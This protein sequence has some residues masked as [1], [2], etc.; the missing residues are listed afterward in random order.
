MSN[1]RFGNNKESKRIY[2][3][4]ASSSQSEKYVNKPIDFNTEGYGE[5]NYDPIYGW[6]E[7]KYGGKESE[8]TFDNRFSTKQYRRVDGLPGSTS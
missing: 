7:Q 5:I 4:L 2:R 1:S 6:L 8:G 3:K